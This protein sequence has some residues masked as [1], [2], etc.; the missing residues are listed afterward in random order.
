MDQHTDL[1]WTE[2]ENVNQYINSQMQSQ[3]KDFNTDMKNMYYTTS[4]SVI[5]ISNLS[6]WCDNYMYY[7]LM[8]TDQLTSYPFLIMSQGFW[9]HT[10]PIQS[11]NI[12]LCHQLMNL[13][14]Y[15]KHILSITSLLFTFID[16][17]SS[18]SL[19]IRTT[20]GR[21]YIFSIPKCLFFL[22]DVKTNLQL[23]G[24][25]LEIKRIEEG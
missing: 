13:L 19:H 5:L 9:H 18:S 7:I 21:S 20:Y 23:E 4:V 17:P 22:I 15:Y 2:T 24:A 25:W 8:L 10:F 16:I 1:A 11:T 12:T 6:L 14:P 3:L